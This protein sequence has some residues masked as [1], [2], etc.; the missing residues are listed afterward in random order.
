MNPTRSADA[1]PFVISRTSDALI[2]HR[3][4]LGVK[5]RKA[6]SDSREDLFLS[7]ELCF[8]M[9]SFSCQTV[10]HSPVE[11]SLG[12]CEAFSFRGDLS[13]DLT[14]FDPL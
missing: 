8:G 7:P 10:G 12:L 4:G 6:F 11:N 14:R 13:R 2:M 9:L 5:G 1:F 3:P